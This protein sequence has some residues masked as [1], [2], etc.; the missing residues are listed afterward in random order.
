MATRPNR[1]CSYPSCPHFA[2]ERGRCHRHQVVRVD[3]RPSSS[4]R[5]YD[6]EW[7][8]IR[9]EVLADQ[10]WCSGCGGKAIEVHHIRA[11]RQ[12]GN[13]D[14][15]NLTPLC[16]SCHRKVTAAERQAVTR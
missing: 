4:A 14:R 10:P 11:L 7:Q 5:G 6:R 3:T 13:H 9:A 8:R 12:G 2:V 16:L 15:S 1:P